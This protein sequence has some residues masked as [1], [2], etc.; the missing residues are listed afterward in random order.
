MRSPFI[1]ANK[2][3]NNHNSDHSNIFWGI[4]RGAFSIILAIV[5][6]VGGYLAI[7]NHIE[8]KIYQTINSPETI[9]RISSR[10]RPSLIFTNK[11]TIEVDMGGL[12]YVSSDIK[13]TQDSSGN[14]Q[15]IKISGL[16]YLKNPPLLSCINY[17]YNASVK[18]GRD[19][20]LIYYLKPIEYTSFF[21]GEINKPDTLFFRLEIISP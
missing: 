15:S 1:M 8:N 11:E 4:W 2:D 3:E 9:Q 17:V 19:K 7:N 16:D 12:E 6:I 13:V 18:R 20:T 10:V 5:A 21:A 14:I